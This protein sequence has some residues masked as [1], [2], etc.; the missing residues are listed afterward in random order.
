MTMDSGKSKNNMSTPQWGGHKYSLPL[1]ED[2]L[3]NF[4]ILTTSLYY[5]NVILRCFVSPFEQSHH[6]IYSELGQ[7]FLI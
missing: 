7:L 4:V 1:A 3:S 6:M 5:D 2:K